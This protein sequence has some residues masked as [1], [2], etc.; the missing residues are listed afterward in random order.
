MQ[1]SSLKG[2]QRFP[3]R[4]RSKS[5][6]DSFAVSQQGQ[7]D[8]EVCESLSLSRNENRNCRVLKFQS[9]LHSHDPINYDW[10]KPPLLTLA[11]FRVAD[12]L[13]GD[14]LNPSEQREAFLDETFSFV[15]FR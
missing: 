4:S 5:C 6:N 8:S 14:I 12:N 3:A 13:T 11:A 15:K 10:V 2:G 9:C 1:P 7:R